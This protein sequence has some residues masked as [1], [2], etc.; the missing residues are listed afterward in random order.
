MFFP[1]ADVAAL[2]GGHSRDFGGEEAKGS[3]QEAE[4]AAFSAPPS[5]AFAPRARGCSWF[6]VKRK[7]PTRE[8]PPLPPRLR[9]ANAGTEATTTAAADQRP[10]ASARAAA[11]DGDVGNVARW[12][13]QAAVLHPHRT[14]M[15][16]F[17][18]RLGGVYYTE[19]TAEEAEAAARLRSLQTQLQRV[20]LQMGKASTQPPQREPPKGLCGVSALNAAAG[21]AVTGKDV[22]AALQNLPPLLHSDFLVREMATFQDLVVDE[23]KEKKKTF[24]SVAGLC[25]RHCENQVRRRE[26]KEGEA[27]RENQRRLRGL[28]SAVA[29]FW[30]KMER[31]VFEHKRRQMQAKL[32]E[33]KERTFNEFIAHALRIS[34]TIAGDIR[35]V[36]R[37]A[38]E[39]NQTNKQPNE[40][41][42]NSAFCAS[43]LS[44]KRSFVKTLRNRRFP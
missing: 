23:H 20:H 26:Q 34:K 37:E 39:L 41:T 5:T 17:F 13:A 11:G 35:L 44:L 27:E 6:A 12:T 2:C 1:S 43:V 42:N 16:L 31:V 33:K 8:P 40:Q 25:R 3:L 29:S 14:D 22:S 7:D 4:Q 30:Q 28:S 10:S 38:L 18:Q 36:R 9:A 32:H 15:R 21:A 19:E 24:K